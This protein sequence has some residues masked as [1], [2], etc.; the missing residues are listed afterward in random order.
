MRLL[1]AT[2]LVDAPA[3]CHAAIDAA[4]PRVSIDVGAGDGRWAYE[5]ARRDPTT[6][7]IALDPDADALAQY[8]FR[9]ARKPARG[10]VANACFVVA[11]AESPPPE[12]AGLATA[13][14]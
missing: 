7:H 3:G 9:A 13:L 8:A 10:G 12:L 2:E 6:F 4:W 11:S 5:Q 1:E 14:Q